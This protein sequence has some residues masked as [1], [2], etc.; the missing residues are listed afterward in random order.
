VGVGEAG[1]HLGGTLIDGSVLDFCSLGSRGKCI[2]VFSPFLGSLEGFEGGGTKGESTGSVESGVGSG[3]E[4]GLWDLK[5]T[6][7]C[8]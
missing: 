5:A 8:D 6:S 3:V 4:N 7:L 1:S 2:E